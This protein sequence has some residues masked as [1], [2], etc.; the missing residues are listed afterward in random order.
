[1]SAKYPGSSSPR[2]AQLSMI[3][4]IAATFGPACGLPM[5]IQFFRP[6]ATGILA[7]FMSSG[8]AILSADKQETAGYAKRNVRKLQV[9]LPV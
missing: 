2:L 4:R 8:G 7:G 3:E 6:S 1:M 5:C 9:P